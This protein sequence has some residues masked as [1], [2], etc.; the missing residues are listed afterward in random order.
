MIEQRQRRVLIVHD[1]P[2]FTA[3]LRIALRGLGFIADAAID[4]QAAI[5]RVL[6]DRPDVVCVSLSLPRD[7]GY[8]LCELIRRSPALNHV[9]ILVISDR[10]SPEIVAY[11]EE[12]GANAFLKHPFKRELLAECM[13]ALLREPQAPQLEASPRVSDGVFALG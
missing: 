9:K 5:P 8:D 2:V 12:A 7:S 3:R 4:G 1:E 10:H 11:A 6:H 13:N